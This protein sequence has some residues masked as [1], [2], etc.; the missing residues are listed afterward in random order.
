VKELDI[1]DGSAAQR[2]DTPLLFHRG[3]Y[4]RPE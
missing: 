1:G 3:A 4:T 2:A